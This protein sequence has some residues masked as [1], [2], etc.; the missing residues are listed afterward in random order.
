LV[1]LLRLYDAAHAGP[2]DYFIWSSCIVLNCMVDFQ[3]QQ[4]L[5]TVQQ[6]QGPPTPNQLCHGVFSS[7]TQDDLLLL[8]LH[9][10]RRLQQ[11]QGSTNTKTSS[12]PAPGSATAD[13]VFFST[14]ASRAD[15]LEQA[16]ESGMSLLMSLAA[17]IGTRAQLS[18]LISLAATAAGAAAAQDGLSTTGFKG[19]APADSPAGPSSAAAGELPERGSDTATIQQLQQQGQPLSGMCSDAVPALLDQQAGTL[20]SIFQG[21][22]RLSGCQ[23]S[24]SNNL[25]QL[26]EMLAALCCTGIDDQPCVLLRLAQQ[27]TREQQVA[28]YSLL[29]TLLKLSATIAAHVGSR[30]RV[31]VSEAALEMLKALLPGSDTAAAAAG[32]AE[33]ID[34]S[35]NSSISARQQGGSSSDISADLWLLLLGRCYQ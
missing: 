22:L 16:A 6:L 1:Q 33:G 25:V 30:C 3:R 4:L 14:A 9:L 8:L 7:T 29:V 15:H 28:F 13:V 31:Y 35:S 12:S 24:T 19:D 17:Q 5:A 23:H 20:F 27:G 11:L 26:T 21:S 10:M 2:G 18:S 34:A 32:P